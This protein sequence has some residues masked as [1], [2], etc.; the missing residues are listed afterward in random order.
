PDQPLDLPV[1]LAHRPDVEVLLQLRAD[2]AVA[3]QVHHYH[4]LLDGAGDDHRHSFLQLRRRDQ[5]DARRIDVAALQQLGDVPLRDALQGQLVA[6]QVERLL[7]GAAEAQG[8][9]EGRSELDGRRVA[10]LAP[11]PDG[12]ADVLDDGFRLGPRVT[13]VQ[14]DHLDV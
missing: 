7:D 10:D 5:D 2:V 8:P 3:R 1:Q 9:V 13:G 11:H 14:D 6:A 4:R 12:A